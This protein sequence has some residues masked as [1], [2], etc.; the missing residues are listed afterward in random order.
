[1]YSSTVLRNIYPWE[2]YLSQDLEHFHHPGLIPTHCAIPLVCQ[3]SVVGRS[4]WWVM[5]VL[6]I[7][8]GFGLHGVHFSKPIQMNS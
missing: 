6:C 4:E 2:Y 3:S 8:V 5:E 7:L 1:M